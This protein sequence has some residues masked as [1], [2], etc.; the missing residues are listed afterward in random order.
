MKYSLKEP[1]KQKEDPSQKIIND[2]QQNQSFTYQEKNRE[3]FNHLREHEFMLIDK[4][5]VD[6][7]HAAIS[8]YVHPGDTVIDLGTGLG[9]LA[10]F[11]AQQ[12]AKKVYAIDHADIISAA[13]RVAEFN[14]LDNIEFLQTHSKQLTLD[15]P[16]DTIIHEQ[17]GNFLLDE[18]MVENI[19]DLRDRLLRKGGRIIPD[20]FELFIE[21]VKFIDSEHVPMIREMK[22]HGIDFSCLQEKGAEE[23]Y[24]FLWRSDPAC[25]EYF[26]CDPQPVYKFNLQT[27]NL[28]DIPTTL[29]YSRPIRHA[30]RL[31]G[32]IVYFRCLLD[33]DIV[34]TTGPFQNRATNWKYWLLRVESVL[35]K[36]GD[37]LQFQLKAQDLQ[38]PSTWQWYFK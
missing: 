21:P 19:C 18:H 23:L 20:T 30:G 15:S 38:I 13:K 3:K 24:A 6:S 12:G 29:S 2:G 16:V 9:I 25:V 10:F 11:A 4:P 31:D 7:Y 8:R 14:K 28:A 26:L 37:I 36:E 5:R 17:M 22:I 35:Y 34:I 32:F 33:D 1:R 27:V